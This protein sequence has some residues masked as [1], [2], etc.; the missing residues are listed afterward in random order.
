M[1]RIKDIK[2]WRENLENTKPYTIA[3]KTTDQVESGFVEITLED[4]TTG[5]GAGNPSHYVTGE[6][7]DACM[8]ALEEK[9]IQFLIGRD[10]RGINQLTYEVLGKM[11]KN[12]A[13]RAAL[14]IAIYDAFT[15]HLGVPLVK[16][17]GQ[18]IKSLPTSNTI[19]IM[20]VE[21]TLKEA[22]DYGKRGFSVLKVKLGINLEE[23]IE[24]MV[25]LR[26]KFGNKFTIRI[27]ANQGYTTEKTIEFYNKTKHLNIEL[28]EQ[29][30]KASAIDEMK[31]L[32]E[33]IRQVIAADESLIS[34]KDAIELVKPPRASGIFNI[35]LMKCGG[36]SQALKIADIAALEGV[37]LFW[38]CNEESIVSIT[39]A[40]H[41]A[42]ACASTR[43]IDLDGSLDLGKDVVKGGFVLKDGVMYCNDKP[44]LGVERI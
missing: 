18:K 31:K 9:N 24:R 1:T 30:L 42:F 7:L 12:P 43:Y 44:G 4:G 39:A 37:D 19:G 32:P 17:L 16:F 38:G 13:A 29:P 34:P 35:K 21:E 14:D 8:A 15:K 20:N 33:E 41:A 40:L 27:D 23:D 3:Y 26:E 36:V 10:I 2:V 25:K 6:T 22:E 5:I 11:P 28:I